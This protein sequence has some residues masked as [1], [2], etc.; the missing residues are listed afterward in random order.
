MRIPPALAAKA[1]TQIL[2]RL[3]APPARILE[4]DFDGIHAVPLRI[5]G[6]DVVVVGGGRAARERAGDVLAEPPSTPFDA[7]IA[8]E[9]TDLTGIRATRALIVKADG[10]VLG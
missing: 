8:R 4:L 1:T 7:V 9:G 3:G 5:A 6:F 2:D 10:S